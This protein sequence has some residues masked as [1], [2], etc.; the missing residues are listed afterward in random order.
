MTLEQYLI[1]RPQLIAHIVEGE[2]VPGDYAVLAHEIG[3]LIHQSGLKIL[4]VNTIQCETELID[5]ELSSGL[6]TESARATKI[7]EKEGLTVLKKVIQ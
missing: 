5:A 1:E 6:L 3:R 2:I 4:L 7:Q